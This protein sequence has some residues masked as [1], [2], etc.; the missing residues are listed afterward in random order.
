MR[1]RDWSRWLALAGL[2]G[3]AGMMLARSTQTAVIGVV[4]LC[5]LV[6]TGI[7]PLPWWAVA[8][9]L[10]MLPYFSY[11]IMDILTN[12]SQRGVAAIFAGLTIVVFLA[13]LDTQ[14]RG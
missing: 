4:P 10:L 14:R 7:K 12:P 11:G 1:S 8:T 2:L 9:A 3:L 6:L 5:L 13:A